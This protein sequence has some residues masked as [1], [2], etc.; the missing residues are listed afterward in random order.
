LTGYLA[1]L[2]AKGSTEPLSARL[3]ALNAEPERPLTQYIATL[4][5]ETMVR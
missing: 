2:R 4:K 1:D 3:V 5:K